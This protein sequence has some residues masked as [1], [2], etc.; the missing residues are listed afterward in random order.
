MKAGWKLFCNLISSKYK[1][2]ID[3]NKYV[4][5]LIEF[6]KIGFISNRRKEYEMKQW[7][8]FLCAYYFQKWV[9]F[10][11]YLFPDNTNL[12]SFF[13][14][15]RTSLSKASLKYKS[16]IVLGDFNID[17]KIKGISQE[18]LEAKSFMTYSV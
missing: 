4:G 15:I 8:H 11:I 6:A 16:L 14:E 3:R 5:G 7:M 12:T 9:R 18:I 17:R 13:N 1:L 2:K 10:S